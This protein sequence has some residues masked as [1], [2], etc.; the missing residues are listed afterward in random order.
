MAMQQALMDEGAMRNVSILW[1]YN[2]F[3]WCHARADN[4]QSVLVY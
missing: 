3:N 2:D 4:E 1:L